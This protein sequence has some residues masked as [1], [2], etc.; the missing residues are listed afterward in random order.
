MLLIRRALIMSA[1]AA[2]AVVPLVSHLSAHPCTHP[3]PPLPAGLWRSRSTAELLVFDKGVCRRYTCYDRLLALVKETDLEDLEQE[4]LAARPDGPGRLEL[5]YWGLVTR[6]QYDRLHGWPALPRLD[7]DGHWLADPGLTVD[8]FF[9]VLA[10]HFAFS[11]ERGINWSALRAECNA[12]LARGSGSPDFLFDTLAATL[13]H[14]EDSHGSL[15]SKEHDADSRSAPSCLYQAWKAASRRSRNGD[16]SASSDPDW[17]GYVQGRILKGAGRTAARDNVAWGRLPSGIGYLSLMACQGLSEDAGGC[18]D[19]AVVTAVLD[20][21][22]A[23][24][25]GVRGII[26]D[27]RFNDGGWDR[28]ALALAA[29]FAA[30]QQPGFTKQAVRSG[31]GLQPQTIEVTPATEPRHTGPVAV[32]TS[33]MTA[34]AAEVAT[35]ALRALP[36][37]RSFGSLTYGGLSDP[38][39]YRLPNGWKGTVSNEI[40]RAIDGQVFENVGIPPD[41]LSIEPCAD[42]FWETLDAPVRDAEAWLLAL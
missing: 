33:D 28:V 30:R 21:V 23:D 18:T 35:L 3:R 11:R 17:L 24:L 32:L 27:L 31:I 2:A 29:R 20:R 7:G 12:A 40:Y 6:I 22:L 25:A 37:T 16:H 42:A 15:W 26:V 9:E 14:L 36:N 10:G 13:R 41:Q 19:V 34:S 39:T 8:A 4:T 1:A 5:E 38:F